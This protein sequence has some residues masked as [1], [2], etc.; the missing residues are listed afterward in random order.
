[1]FA[2]RAETLVLSLASV[3]LG[4]A[5]AA[6]AGSFRLGVALL[7][8]LTASWLHL[9][10]NLA[11]DYGDLQHGADAINPVRP[12]SALQRQLISIVQTKRG[13][14]WLL[15]LSI[16]TGAAL[17]WVAQLSVAE[18]VF[19]GA[20]GVAA[21]ASAVGYTMGR[22]PYGYRGW[23]DLAVFC[24]FGIVGV[25]GTFYLQTHRLELYLWGLPAAS[26]G[27]LVQGVLHINNIRDLIYDAQAGKHTMAV[28]WGD[29]R[30]RQIH[31]V[32]LVCS[33]VLSVWFLYLQANRLPWSFSALATLPWFVRHG[34]TVLHAPPSALTAELQC[35]VKIICAFTASLSVGMVL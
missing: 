2:L 33:G 10:C 26:Y 23:G 11:N 24:F 7:C 25:G 35:L 9:L 8:A 32:V 16:C 15:A 27:L 4:S 19:F 14:Q 22:R 13:I 31:C 18:Y 6:F 1:M 12:P 29:R 21:A 28:V 30:A 5:L 17:L 34:R 3:G 20:L